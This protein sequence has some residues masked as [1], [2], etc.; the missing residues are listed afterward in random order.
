MDILLGDGW[1][2]GIWRRCLYSGYDDR[3]RLE[4]DQGQIGWL[5]LLLGK[6]GGSEKW[7]QVL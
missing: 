4:E 7:H 6:T 2:M 5:T 1:L 3:R